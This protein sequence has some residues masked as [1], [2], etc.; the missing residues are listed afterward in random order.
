MCLKNGI[1]KAATLVHHIKPVTAENVHDPDI[2]LN[3]ENLM[4]LCV[5]CHA[6]IHST[7]RY[8]IDENGNV[9]VGA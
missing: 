7:R 9:T 3:P 5:D 4:T 8:Y 1:Y 6:A 2:T